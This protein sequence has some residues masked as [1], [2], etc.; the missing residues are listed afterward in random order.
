MQTKAY[1]TALPSVSG[2]I[3]I[4]WKK[5]TELLS[6]QVQSMYIVEF[7]LYVKNNPIHWIRYCPKYFL[8][9]KV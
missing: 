1:T 2:V 7:H 4:I 8:S 6:Q 5:K 3:R 9:K